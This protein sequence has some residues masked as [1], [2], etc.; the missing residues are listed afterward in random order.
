M[1]QRFAPV[2]LVKEIKALKVETISF[3][4]HENAL[5]RIRF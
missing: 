5:L 3:Q 4:E 1:P 2:I